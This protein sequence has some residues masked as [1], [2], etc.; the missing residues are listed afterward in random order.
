MDHL[1]SICFSVISGAAVAVLALDIGGQ[2]A[3]HPE[4]FGRDQVT[5]Q[6]VCAQ[7]GERGTWRCTDADPARVMWTAAR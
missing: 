2:L 4:R 1:Q 3:E 5:L 7:Y 6:T